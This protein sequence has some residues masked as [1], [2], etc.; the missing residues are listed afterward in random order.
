[1][2]RV[3]N[4]VCAL[5]ATTLVVASC[6]DYESATNLHPEGPPMVQQ[7]RMKETYTTPGSTDSSTRRVFGFGTHPDAIE[8]E[9]HAVTSASVVGNAFRVVMDELLIGNNLEEIACRSQIDTD[10]FSQV[11]LGATPDDIAKCATAQDVLPSTCKGQFATCICALPGG[12]AVGATMVPMGGPVGVDDKNQDG[13]ADDTQLIATAVGIQCGTIQV[14][15]DLNKSYWNPS[16]NQQPPAM[17]GFDAL[18]PAI[19]LVP[20][21]GLPTNLSC[22][23][24]FGPAV[25]DKQNVQVCAPPGGDIDSSCNP[26]DTYAASFKTEPMV[27][28][29]SSITNGQTGVNRTEDV[30]FVSNTPLDPSAINSITVTQG[31]TMV[32]YTNFTVTLTMGKILAVKWGGTGLLPNTMYTITVN[33]T[34]KDTFMQPLPAPLVI[35]FTTGA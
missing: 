18:G 28:T 31:P 17:G 32:P 21:N 23:L 4:R 24:T 11:P 14:P 1:M 8:V 15:M 30:L 22:H 27:V 3:L 2:N 33:T 7:V 35:S 19:V 34:L 5:V 26:G 13:A 10:A 9:A 6:T 12:C 25:V 29:T 20:L 16:G